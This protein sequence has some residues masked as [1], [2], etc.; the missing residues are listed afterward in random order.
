MSTKLKIFIAEDCPNCVEAR[1]I[2]ARIEQNYP[3]FPIEVIDIGDK[4]ATVPEAV[5]ATPTFMLDERIVSL[6]NP[7]FEEVV[8]WVKDAQI[9]S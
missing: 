5:F 6:G 2:A 1:N 7:A 4:Q 8:E 3:E 9:T